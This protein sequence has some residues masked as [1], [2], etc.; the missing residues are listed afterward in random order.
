LSYQIK[1]FDTTFELRLA[2]IVFHYFTHNSTVQSLTV[3]EKTKS[4]MFSNS[5]WLIS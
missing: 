2:D 3:F 4:K 1:Y 5:G